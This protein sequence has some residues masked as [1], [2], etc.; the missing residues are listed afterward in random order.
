M[1]DPILVAKI[2]GLASVVDTRFK[3]H[4]KEQAGVVAWMER[5]ANGLDR[6]VE[7]GSTMTAVQHRIAAV[8]HTAR[9]QALD[10]DGLDTRMSDIES[11]RK[12]DGLRSSLTKWGLGATGGA[13][14]AYA[15]QTFLGK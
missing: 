7:M 4:E 5:L 8:E 14:V 10:I 15:V 13:L 6:L 2:D 9:D 11:N 3:A 1:S 12:A